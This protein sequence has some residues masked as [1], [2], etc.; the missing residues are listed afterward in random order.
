[1]RLNSDERKAI[2]A[3]KALA[4]NWPD[5]LWL[6]SGGGSLCVMKKDA[7]GDRVMSATGG[8]GETAVVATI[9]IENDGGD[10][11]A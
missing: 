10:F 11:A 9:E 1:M 8:Y 2:N 5:S 4:K 6:F 7:A 3:L